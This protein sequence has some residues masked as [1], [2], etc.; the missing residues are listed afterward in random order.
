MPGAACA[1]SAASLRR[2]SSQSL[3][4]SLSMTVISFWTSVSSGSDVV[5]FMVKPSTDRQKAFD[6]AENSESSELMVAP[7]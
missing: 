6:A 5:M 7:P 1:A 3:P 2:S 4:L